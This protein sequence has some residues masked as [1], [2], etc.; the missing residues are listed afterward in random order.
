MPTVKSAIRVLEVF[1]YF[2]RVQR[3]ASVTEI[4]RELGYPQSSTSVL[5][6][7]LADLGYLRHGADQR[8]YF[9]TPRVAMLGSWVEPMVAP[10]G[11]LR[12]L[13]GELGE[14]TGET[15]ILATPLR[16]QVQY[17]HVVPAT[18]TMRMHV[19]PG[20]LRPLLT[21]GLGRLFAADLA[22]EQLRRMVLRHNGGAEAGEEISVA[23]L[24]RDLAA[25]RNSGFSISLNRITSGAG[26]IG[27]RLPVDAGGAPLALGIG[28]WSRTI[29]NEQDRYLQLLRSAVGRYFEP[30]PAAARRC[31]GRRIGA[32]REAA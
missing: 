24:R 32:A 29:R 21:S 6:R 20:T 23:A 4:A 17:V 28:G 10:G 9:P 12:Q 13:M 3:E 5:L 15:I 16:D 11:S 2:D 30:P 22:D 19:G 18:T 8:S 7:N 1:E 14:L 25:I 27:I 31:S 26:V